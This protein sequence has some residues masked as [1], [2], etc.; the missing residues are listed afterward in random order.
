MDADLKWSQFRANNKKESSSPIQLVDNSKAKSKTEND[1]PII[2]QSLP[3]I[4]DTPLPPSKPAIS[5][6]ENFKPIVIPVLS[7]KIFDHVP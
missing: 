4:M 5:E 6:A 1:L 3:P 7:D 2:N